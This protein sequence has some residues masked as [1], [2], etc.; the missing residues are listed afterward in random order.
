MEA[1]R[2]DAHVNEKECKA[3]LMTY[4]DFSNIMHAYAVRTLSPREVVM[5]KITKSKQECKLCTW[6]EWYIRVCGCT[7]LMYCTFEIP[8][9]N[10]YTFMRHTCALTYFPFEMRNHDVND[11]ATTSFD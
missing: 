9:T 5:Q 4:S 7:W 6:H 2:E 3:C 10:V 11:D 8:F 1:A